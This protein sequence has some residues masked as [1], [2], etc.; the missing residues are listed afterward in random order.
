MG[1][2]TLWLQDR[3]GYRWAFVDWRSPR[4]KDL[5]LTDGTVGNAPEVV[6]ASCD[7]PLIPAPGRKGA[8]RHILR[9]MR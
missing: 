9:K 8:E 2:P 7:H 1:K 4:A 5:Y 3:K 6:T